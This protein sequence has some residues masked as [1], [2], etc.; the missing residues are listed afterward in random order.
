M[1]V[2]NNVLTQILGKLDSLDTRMDKL[3][4]RMDSLEQAQTAIQADVRELQASQADARAETANIQSGIT[5]I[6]VT[7]IL[8]KSDLKTV[9]G[10]AVVLENDLTRGVKQLA[11]GHTGIAETLKRHSAQLDRLEQLIPLVGAH[12]A[13]LR[14]LSR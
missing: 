12:D 6:Q 2:E 7:A 14:D 9:K 1:E 13:A 10:H 11:E 8:L 3:D 5:E 4:T